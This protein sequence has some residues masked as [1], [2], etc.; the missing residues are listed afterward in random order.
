MNHN[1]YNSGL[2]S[3]VKV[4]SALTKGSAATSNVAEAGYSAVAG[5]A[6]GVFASQRI[7]SAAKSQRPVITIK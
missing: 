6:R 4:R 7:K 2:K 5:F 1:T 3:G